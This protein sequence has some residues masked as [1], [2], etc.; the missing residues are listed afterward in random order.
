ML[1][2]PGDI[3][4]AVETSRLQKRRNQAVRQLRTEANRVDPLANVRERVTRLPTA[5]APAPLIDVMLSPEA[6]RFA[7]ARIAA[8]AKRAAQ[9]TAEQRSE[10]HTSELQSLMRIS[11]AVI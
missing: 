8:A 4:G 6:E 9:P 11:Y 1:T 10:E 3:S 7:G 2:L 5:A